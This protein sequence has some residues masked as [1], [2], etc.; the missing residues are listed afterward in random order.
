MESMRKEQGFLS[1]LINLSFDK[2]IIKNKDD[3][4]LCKHILANRNKAQ[5]DG[6]SDKLNP[7][8]ETLIRKLLEKISKE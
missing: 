6:A 1:K 5:H 8:Y 3:F 4:N 7:D 2:G